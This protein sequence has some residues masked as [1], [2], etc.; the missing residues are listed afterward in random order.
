MIFCPGMRS[1]SQQG[2]NLVRVTKKYCDS[3]YSKDIDRFPT[4]K[5]QKVVHVNFKE[6]LKVPRAYER[7]AGDLREVVGKFTTLRKT[8]DLG[9]I[10][11]PP[12]E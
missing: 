5:L 12:R 11:Q 9:A 1:S 7:G 8:L 4:P 2:H 6:A 3:P 10:K